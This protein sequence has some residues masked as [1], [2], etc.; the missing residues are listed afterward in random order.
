MKLKVFNGMVMC[1]PAEGKDFK[2]YHVSVCEKSGAAARRLLES[3]FGGTF[4]YL[5]F[6]D[7]W[8]DCWGNSMDEIV[9][10]TDIWIES[11]RGEP[12]V[13]VV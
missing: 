4:S 1:K 9:P 13:R 7:Y 11:E 12:P 10:E 8:S 5:Y 2:Q 6:R 3:Y